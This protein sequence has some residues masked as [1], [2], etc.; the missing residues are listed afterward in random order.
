MPRTESRITKD[1]FAE[2]VA[3]LSPPPEARYRRMSPWAILLRQ[4]GLELW[5]WF[6]P[7]SGIPT[8]IVGVVDKDE[9]LSPFDWPDLAIFTIRLSAARYVLRRADGTFTTS[10]A[11]DLKNMRPRYL[12]EGQPPETRAGQEPVYATFDPSKAGKPSRAILESWATTADDGGK[13]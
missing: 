5:D 2:E 7:R 8:Q 10:Y 4:T 6:E 9:V 13:E 3:K 1:N 11:H 12:Y